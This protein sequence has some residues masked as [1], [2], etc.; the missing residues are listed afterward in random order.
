MSSYCAS[1]R[2]LF[3]YLSTLRQEYKK[4]KKNITISMGCPYIVRT[5]M[6]EGFKTKIGFILRTLDE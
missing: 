5:T 3:G 4:A 2:A 1:K 6:F